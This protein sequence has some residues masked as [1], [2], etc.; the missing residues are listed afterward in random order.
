MVESNYHVY[1]EHISLTKIMQ[2]CLI[3]LTSMVFKNPAYFT[4][5][6]P[7]DNPL[8]YKTI[9]TGGL[10]NRWSLTQ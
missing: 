3:L 9:L 1:D 4:P 7:Y 2:I 6:M 8:L 5:Y 10:S